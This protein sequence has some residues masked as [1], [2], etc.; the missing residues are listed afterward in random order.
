MKRGKTAAPRAAAAGNGVGFC[1]RGGGRNGGQSVK[2]A[3]CTHAGE[4]GMLKRE[5]D[6]ENLRDKI[7]MCGGGKARP[8]ERRKR[9]TNRE[10]CVVVRIPYRRCQWKC[11][12][13]CM[14]PLQIRVPRTQTKNVTT[15]RTST[16]RIHAAPTNRPGRGCLL[17]EHP[18]SG[19]FARLRTRAGFQNGS[20]D[21]SY[22][23]ERK[24]IVTESRC[25][26][27][28]ANR[29]GRPP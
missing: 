12:T 14:P 17:G 9:A 7:T 23:Q 28:N 6:V 24:G 29:L 20:P 18:V 1:R 13:A 22:R 3:F 26:V 19:R 27:R 8:T 16:G 21:E 25:L 2:P 10:P 11:G 4:N 5:K 15:G